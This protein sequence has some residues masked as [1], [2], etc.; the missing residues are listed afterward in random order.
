M[1]SVNI[2]F[3]VVD[4]FP[5]CIVMSPDLIYCLKIVF[6]RLTELAYIQLLSAGI[7]F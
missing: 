3:Q 6:Q 2:Q 4:N 1:G 7:S 5:V